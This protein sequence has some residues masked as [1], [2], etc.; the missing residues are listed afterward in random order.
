MRR[1]SHPAGE[2]LFYQTADGHTRV[3]CR[4]AQET[5][6]LSQAA[7]AELFQTT[8]QNVAKH[9]KAIFAEG[10]LAAES[11]VSQWLTT[12][13]DGNSY[14]VRLLPQTISSCGK[15]TQR[16]SSSVI[17]A[18]AG[19][20]APGFWTPASAGV[21]AKPRGLMHRGAISARQGHPVKRWW[22]WPHTV[23][24]KKGILP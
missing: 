5:L 23:A 21:M 6:W 3:E 11:V 2:F 20:Q 4:F 17:P 15:S 7:M 10:E 13:A 16:R 8:K 22:G 24:A 12:A 9:L 14:Q 19:I 1:V 18:N